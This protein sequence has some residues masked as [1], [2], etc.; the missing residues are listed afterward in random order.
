MSIYNAFKT[1]WQ[2]QYGFGL[3]SL[4][5]AINSGYTYKQVAADVA[6][7]NVGQKAQIN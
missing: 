6:G 5:N 2:G 7:K 3:N 4:N 1:Y